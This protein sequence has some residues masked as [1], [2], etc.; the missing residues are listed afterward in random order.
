MDTYTYL[1]TNK[2]TLKSFP[3]Y[4]WIQQCIFCSEHTSMVKHI[5]NYKV[6]CCGKCLTNTCKFI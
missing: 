3:I 6:Y 5:R 4:G 1:S 2:N